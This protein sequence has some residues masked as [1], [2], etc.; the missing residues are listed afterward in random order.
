MKPYR[1]IC[2]NLQHLCCLLVTRFSPSLC[3]V[4]WMWTISSEV[5]VL[6]VIF[7]KLMS[8]FNLYFK[9]SLQV[10]HQR[11]KFLCTPFWNDVGM[12]GQIIHYAKM[13]A[14][15]LQQTWNT[16]MRTFKNE[17]RVRAKLLFPHIIIQ[18]GLNRD[19][20]L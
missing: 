5:C 8:K 13:G 20:G 16:E 1:G 6:P 18:D 4:V 2:Q 17:M 10:I 3:F 7:N 9:F 11:L 15:L 14:N 19:W 12:C